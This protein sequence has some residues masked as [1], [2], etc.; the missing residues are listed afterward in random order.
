MSS[1]VVRAV[2]SEPKVKRVRR[3]N[4]EERQQLRRQI[5][6]AAFDI[7]RRE[8]LAGLSMRAVAQAVGVSAMALY[9]YFADKAELI[10]GLWDFVMFDLHQVIAE[11]V[12]SEAT[13]RARLRASTEAAISYW[14][15]H[16][17]HFRL[18]FMT[19]QTSQPGKGAPL[20]DMPSYRH[21]VELVRNLMDDWADE[22]GVDRSGVE[23][24]RDIRLSM[25][26][27]YL[28]ARHIN[29]RYT[30]SNLDALRAQTV[31]NIV[32]AVESCLRQDDVAA[33]VA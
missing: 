19:E 3:G 23:L 29:R 11:A 9:R 5:L 13:P 27:G 6:E 31:G 25:M 15:R 22:L 33:S 10:Q 18:V 1:T 32:Q 26:V 4:L 30:W 14:E 2:S 12:T 17:E 21:V 8:G 28:H 16:P 20:T 7:Y 24:A